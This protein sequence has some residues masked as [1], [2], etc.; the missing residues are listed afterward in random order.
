LAS[1]FAGSGVGVRQSEDFLT[2]S[3]MKLLGN[4]AANP[5]TALTA[6]RMEVMHDRGIRELA[7]S[8]LEEAVAVGQASGAK[9][10]KDQAQK[11]LAELSGYSHSG[12]SSMLYDRLAGR[13]LEHDYLTGA[14]VRA[15]ARHGIDVPLNRA[16][17][18]IL[19]ALSEG[20]SAG[21]KRA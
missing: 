17:L 9:L 6:R 16:V 15:A 13:P 21:R 20:F 4:L 3:W 12:G 19:A 2:A 8:L 1:L 5:M 10:A 7:L 11:T 14:V 18:A